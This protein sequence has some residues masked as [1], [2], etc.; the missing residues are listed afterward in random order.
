MAQSQWLPLAGIDR[1]RLSVARPMAHYAAQWL[2]RS[3]RGY[4]A[5]KP[6]DSHSNLGW[7]NTL[8]GFTTHPL[9]D[10]SQLGLRLRD[11]TLTITAP[12]GTTQSSFALAGRSE[13][14]IRA[15][16]GGVVSAKGLDAQALDA[17]SPYEMP[18]FAIA[19]GGPYAADGE[20][21][22]ALAA[23]YANANT[24]LEEARRGLADRG[25][26]A[27]AVRCWPHHF[28]LD[29]LVY[30]S[31]GKD[32]RSMGLG[33]SPG[34]DYYD[35]PY[36]YVS[37]YPAPAVAFPPLPSIAHWHTHHFTAAVAPASRI[38]AASDQCG[39]TRS[40]LASAIDFASKALGQKVTSGIAG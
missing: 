19:T 34:D 7:D 17:A 6:D 2:A 26:A 4:I 15:W 9:P 8:G 29:S 33:F 21:L 22:G 24:V 3:A 18:P 40:Y 5:A 25:L 23:W 1:R 37:L 38:L 16:L 14:D 27:P 36:F 12:Q 30:F 28:D 20:A 39:E 31:T 13:A 35:E 10:G 11:L 32:A